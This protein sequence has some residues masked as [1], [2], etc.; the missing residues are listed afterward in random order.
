M[1]GTRWPPPGTATRPCGSTATSQPFEELGTQPT[2]TGRQPA[3]R[4]R[5]FLKPD[6]EPGASHDRTHPLHRL[7]VATELHQF[8]DTQV[9]PGT[10]VDSAAFWKGFDAIVADLA[11][12]NI[13]LLAERDRL[14]TELDDWHKAHP[15]PIRTWHEGLPRLPGEDRLPGAATC[16]R[17]GHHAKTWTPS[18]PPGRPAAG[19]AHPQRALCAQ[20]R[21]RALGF[22]VRR[23][24]RHRRHPRAD[25]ADKGKGYNPV[26]GAKVIEYARHVLDRTAPLKKGSHVDSHRLCGAGGKLVVTLKNGKTHR[27]E[28][29]PAVGRLP[30]RRRQPVVGAAAAQRP[31]PGHPH[32]PQH[33]IGARTPPA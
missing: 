21:Q 12:A 28:E 3:R 16:Q 27:T 17:E 7:Q 30:G 26:R 32:R 23:A 2:R 6:L 20:R 29:R 25:G 13:A 10:G 11:P 22:A 8:I 18:W 31:A 5:V 33:A 4:T 19:G 14:Q 1:P 9:L 24:V 15:G